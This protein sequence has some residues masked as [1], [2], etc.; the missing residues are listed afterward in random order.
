M[1]LELIQEETT[2][3]TPSPGLQGVE[4]VVKGVADGGLVLLPPPHLQPA[5]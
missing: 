3:R 5:H 2:P 4:V 1:R